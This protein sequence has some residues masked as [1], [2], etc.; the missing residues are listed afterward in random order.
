M[1]TWPCAINKH[2]YLPLATSEADWENHA[3]QC[4]C[5]YQHA[6]FVAH[7]KFS[8][9]ASDSAVDIVAAKLM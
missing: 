4:Q 8:K 3:G 7:L 5:E 1:C 9:Y 2:E 6:A